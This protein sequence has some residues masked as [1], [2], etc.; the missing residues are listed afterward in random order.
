MCVRRGGEMK[1][2][3]VRGNWSKQQHYDSSGS[4]HVSWIS[5]QM[6]V[7]LAALVFRQSNYYLVSYNLK[8]K[9]YLQRDATVYSWWSGCIQ[10]A[11]ILSDI[12]NIWISVSLLL[13]HSPLI[14]HHRLS[15]DTH[16]VYTHNANIQCGLR[17]H[18]FSHR[19]HLKMVQLGP[20]NEN[21]S[22][23][24]LWVREV[25]ELQPV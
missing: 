25:L 14:Y 17:L 4:G 23:K 5:V 22:S 1:W 8:V 19:K 24:K 2:A 9:A 7:Q 10:H 15:A 20:R 13:R 6:V 11:A 3:A 16:S 12:C 21:S 18:R